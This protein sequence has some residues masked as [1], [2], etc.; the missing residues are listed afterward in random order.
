LLA[1]PA[2]GD[3]PYQH[4]LYRELRARG[5]EVSDFTRARLV[6]LRADVVHLHWPD[7]VLVERRPVLR[8]LKAFVLLALLWIARIRRR[9]LVW[10]VHNPF[11]RAEQATRWGPA[12]LHQVARACSGLIFLSDEHR[13]AYGSR[14]T[15]PTAVIPQPHYRLV[16]GEPRAPVEAK[17]RLALGGRSRV[18]GFFGQVRPY[19][20]L[21]ALQ[22]AFADLDDD[23][24]RLLV[25][26]DFDE[27]SRD[28]L[29]HLSRDA[30]AVVLGRRVPDQQVADVLAAMDVLVLPYRELGNSAVALLALSYGRPVLAPAGV[31]S[32]VD[33]RATVGPGWVSLFEGEL[34]AADLERA[35]HTPPGSAE[36]DLRRY[37][38]E[39]IGDLTH[40][41]LSSLVDRRRPRAAAV[42]GRSPIRRARP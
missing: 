10:T 39:R 30:R 14:P 5:W 28:L 15:T 37:D 9:D 21:A 32:I 25:A 36:P 42:R 13:G 23:S 12:F 3:N 17:E 19:K 31:P 2:G 20:N 34:S 40:R 16:Y 22:R 29:A 35:L 8:L 41:F 27:S 33:F 6:G 1:W 26:G 4:L 7:L 11:L 24:A 18:V 38:R